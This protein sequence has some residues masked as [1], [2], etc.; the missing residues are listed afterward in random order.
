MYVLKRNKVL[1]AILGDAPA[2]TAE[3]VWGHHHRLLHGDNLE[4][5]Q[6]NHRNQKRETEK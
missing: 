4:K 5:D 6:E 2:L 3:M 1:W